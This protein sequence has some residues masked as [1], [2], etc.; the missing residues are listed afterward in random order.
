MGFEIECIPKEEK[1][2]L[3]ENHNYPLGEN[4]FIL[5]RWVVDKDRGAK[6]VHLNTYDMRGDGVDKQ[7]DTFALYWG[8]ERVTLETHST[9]QNSKN[10]PLV[11]NVFFSVEL[12]NI[13]SSFNGK[14]EEVREL[15]SE[16]LNARGFLNNPQKTANV[17]VR[18]I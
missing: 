16:A 5:K 18:F 11:K 12:I 7:Q 2:K 10:N 9:I 3:L 1:L 15:I 6:L 17:E 13:P 4:S 14:V 8:V